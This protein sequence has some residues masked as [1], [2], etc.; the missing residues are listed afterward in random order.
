MSAAAPSHPHEHLI[1]PGVDAP[2]VLRSALGCF[3][4]G[5]TVITAV[6][7]E[8]PFGITANSFASVSLD[9]ALVLWSPA[10]SSTRFAR[11]TAVSHYTIHVL[12]LEQ[13][14]LSRR[15]TKGG[16]AF[17]GLDHHFNPEGAPVIPGTLARFECRQWAVQDAGDHAIIIG[18]VLRAAHR[19]G[20]PLGFARGQFGHFTPGS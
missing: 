11:F 1:T 13:G 8:G 12:G 18:Q 6:D 4:T 15:F 19:E 17:D 16:A 3:A 2:H 20:D 5:V 14:E 7:A 9:P 10:K